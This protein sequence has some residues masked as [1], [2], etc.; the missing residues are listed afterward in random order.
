MF[1]AIDSGA[2]LLGLGAFLSGLGGFLTGF[3]AL[4]A[5]RR[6]NGE[7]ETPKKKRRWRG[8]SDA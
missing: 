5:A 3:A 4:K 7:P 6:R 1:L 2:V 8:G